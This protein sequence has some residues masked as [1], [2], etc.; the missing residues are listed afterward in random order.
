MRLLKSIRGDGLQESIVSRVYA[1]LLPSHF[2]ISIDKL[3][4]NS[5]N[6]LE[7]LLMRKRG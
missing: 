1:L 5:Y 3:P 7:P 4:Q 2:K 6:K